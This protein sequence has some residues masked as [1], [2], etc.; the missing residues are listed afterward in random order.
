MHHATPLKFLMPG[1]FA[2]V[3]G[4]TGLSLAWHRAAP[5]MGDWAGAA[6]LVAAL[7]A[8]A[9]FVLLLAASVLRWQR[10]PQ[11]LAE[12]LRHPVRHAFVA[13]VP[14]SLLLLATAAVALDGPGPVAH[15]AWAIASA[16][17]LAVTVW[18]MGRWLSDKPGAGLAW[19]SIT[20]ILFIP[21]VGNVVV[22]L[23]GVALGH[24]LWSAAQFAIG[25]LLWP[26]ALAL[27]AVRIGTQGLWPQ[28]LLPATFITVAPPAVI[29]LAVLQLGAPVM[30]AWAAWGVAL[31]FLLWSGTVV[32]RMLAQPFGV[33]FWGLSFPLAAFAA[34]SLRLA[35]GEAA[36]G[37]PMVL[38][39]M[40]AL[41]LATLVILALSL[42]TIRGL[43]SGDL[44]VPE[45]VA[46]LAP[47][48]AS[49]APAPMTN[50]AASPAPTP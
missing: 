5:L 1:W 4:W 12:D 23:A 47:A 38:W 18:A 39:A 20:P 17:E 30:L 37:Q 43:L 24:P 29:G 40:L 50:P 8:G 6:S 42:A 19:P 7:V 28:R 45:P 13:A 31:F 14:I 3:M 27:L 22:P 21:I 34:L 36:P 10:Y 46:T 11:A 44:L 16:L 25:L 15:T 49:G 26:V 32:R 35:S 33:P 48:P 9:V 41:A 2:I